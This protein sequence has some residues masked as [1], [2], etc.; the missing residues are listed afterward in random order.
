MEAA[1]GN[2]AGGSIRKAL[3]HSPAQAHAEAALEVLRFNWG[4]AYEIGLD[5]GGWW[6]RRRDGLGGTERAP[7]PDELH[8]LIVEDYSFRPVRRDDVR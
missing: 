6:C 2:A 7:G 1:E 3:E 8:K 5:D 4:E